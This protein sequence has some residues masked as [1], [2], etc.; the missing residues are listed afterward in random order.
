MTL[1]KSNLSTASVKSSSS[2]KIENPECTVWRSQDQTLLSWLLSSITEGILSLVHSCNTSFDV[3]KALE[4]RFGVQSGEYCLKMKQ[5]TDKLACAGSPVLYRDMLKQILNGLG[6]GY[7]DLATFIT[8]S[9]LDYDDAYALLLTHEARLEQSQS[10]KHIGFP[11]GTG[12][13]GNH[14]RNQMIM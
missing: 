6:A 3:W 7:L 11:A 8:T 9:K 2:S 12:H 14:G 5:V 10:E 13:F 4:K 1:N